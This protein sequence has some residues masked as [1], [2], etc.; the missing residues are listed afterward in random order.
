[1]ILEGALAIWPWTQLSA[2][3]HDPLFVVGGNR[4]KAWDQAQLAWEPIKF[5]F[6]LLI[7]KGIKDSKQSLLWLLRQS[8]CLSSYSNQSTLIDILLSLTEGWG[9]NSK[10]EAIEIK[11]IKHCEDSRCWTGWIVIYKRLDLSYVC[12]MRHFQDL[13]KLYTFWNTRVG[14]LRSCQPQLKFW[15]LYYQSMKNNVEK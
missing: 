2:W 15:E 14:V 6:F 10:W 5:F 1:M 3:T 9:Q 8:T 4:G 7:K 13:F 11:A 12:S